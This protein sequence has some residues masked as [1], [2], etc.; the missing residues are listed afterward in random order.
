[1]CLLLA[2]RQK[3]ISEL[4][5]F[6]EVP[7]VPIRNLGCVLLFFFFIPQWNYFYLGFCVPKAKLRVLPGW[8]KCIHA[9]NPVSVNCTAYVSPI[10]LTFDS[11]L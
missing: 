1:M 11:F 8:Q 6:T 10:G 5:L 2:G 3:C 7:L 4:L 9:E